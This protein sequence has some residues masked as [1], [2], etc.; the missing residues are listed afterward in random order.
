MPAWGIFQEL[1]IVSKFEH[2][3][4]FGVSDRCSNGLTVF[5]S[6]VEK[7]SVMQM[8][9]TILSV[10]CSWCQAAEPRL[11]WNQLKSTEK[12]SSKKSLNL[13]LW[14]WTDF[15]SW[16]KLLENVLKYR[17]EEKGSSLCRCSSLLGFIMS[18][19]LRGLWFYL[20][21]KVQNATSLVFLT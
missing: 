17:S 13:L 9:W 3:L 20:L 11:A 12:L 21:I 19:N 4:I 15:K 18:K 10:H 1:K 6:S 7:S 2:R 14:L 8:N 5:N 16:W